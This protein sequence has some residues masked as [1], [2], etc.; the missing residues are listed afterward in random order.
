MATITSQPETSTGFRTLADIIDRIGVPAHR[1]LAWPAPGTATVDDVVALEAREDRL[2]E[3]VDGV[4]VEKAY[5]FYESILACVLIHL[6]WNYLETNPVGIVAGEG[7]MMRL[8]PGLVRIPDV[9]VVFW[10]R[11]PDRRVTSEPVPAIAPDLA[12]EVLSESN[13]KAE[14]DRKLR[15]YFAAGARLVWYL[16]PEDR[17][18]RVYTAVDQ[19]TLIDESGT[20]DGGDV[21]PGFVLPIR[22]WFERAERPFAGRG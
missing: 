6:L 9:S 11:F 1:I 19:V 20:L 5:G 8:A 15:E 16:D 17:T 12:V 3:L 2:A 10:D 7:G 21:L 22:E 13:T 18:V 4:L 14:M